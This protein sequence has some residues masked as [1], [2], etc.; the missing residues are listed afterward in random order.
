MNWVPHVTVATVVE[1]NS[2]FLLVHE[3][4]KDRGRMVYNQPAGHWD[5]GESLLDAAIREAQ[6]ETAWR[7][8]LRYWLGLYSYVAPSNGFT[9]LRVAF[10]GQTLE[11]LNMP[12]D[13]GIHAAVWLDY[14]TICEKQQAGELRSPL[15][16]QVIDDYRA[17][18]NLP[19]EVIYRHG[20]HAAVSSG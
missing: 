14:A 12:L 2:L 13:E 6:E 8:E 10:V 15:V 5:E 4:D 11:R 19:L 1:E 18:R 9:Y 17:G 7:V 3:W 16:L 20:N